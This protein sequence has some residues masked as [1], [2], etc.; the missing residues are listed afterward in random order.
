M[1]PNKNPYDFI[2]DPSQPSKS[3]MSFGGGKKKIIPI[4][5]FLS[6]VV[7]IIIVGVSLISS[8][9]KVNNQDLINVR[10]QQTELLRIIDIGKKDLSDIA[11]KN[12]L[13]TLEA[14]VAS[15][16]KQIADLLKGREEVTTSLAL[17][18]LRDKDVDAAFDA[19]KQDGTYDKVVLDEISKRSNAYFNSLKTALNDSASNKETRLLEAAITNL[20]STVQ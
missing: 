10:A 16:E 11:L 5:L 8:V 7:V 3:G 20:Q 9:G 18:S 2:L 14:T 13:A 4:L 17:K 12:N 19:A 1:Q 6:A 15:D